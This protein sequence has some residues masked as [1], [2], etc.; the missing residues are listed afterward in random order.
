F[1]TNLAAGAGRGDLVAAAVE[2]LL[3]SSVDA[4]L[5]AS[6]TAFSTR[7]TDGVTYSQGEGA[8][9]FGVSALQ[10]AA[11]SSAT[12]DGQTF[13]LTTD[14][15]TPAMTTGDDTITATSLTLSNDDRITDGSTT[16]NDTLNITATRTLPTAM[17][18]TNVENIVIDWDSYA[19]PD[20]DLTE[21]SGSTVTISSS[22]Q[23]YFGHVDFDGVGTNAVVAGSGMDGD[24]TTDDAEDTT[25][26]AD[27]AN[28]LTMT[29]GDGALTVNA[30]AAE[31]ISIAGGDS[32]VLNA[33]AADDVTAN[34]G[35]FDTAE[36]NL[37]VDAD[38]TFVGAADAVVTV[39][40]A[41]DIT[42]SIQNGFVGETITLG[43]DGA[44]TL[45]FATAADAD[46]VAVTNGGVVN[47]SG[48]ISAALDLS[49]VSASQIRIEST[50]DANALTVASGATVV[51]EIDPGAIAVVAPGT[52]ADSS[53]DTLNVIVE[54]D[55]T[56][57]DFATA[58]TN[59]FETVNMDIDE[60][61]GTGTDVTIA[62]IVMGTTGSTLTVTSEENDLEVT[63]L[64]AET[65]DFSGVASDVTVSQVAAAA[66]DMTISGSSAGDN[67]V[68]FTTD[69]EEAIYIGGAGDD[70]VTFVTD[71]GDATAS[72]GDG[73]NTVDA[74]AITTGVLS[75]IGGTG[76]DNVDV[77][78]LTTGSV[79]LMLGDGDNTMV[80]GANTTLGGA[81]VYIETGAGDDTLTID[82]DTNATDEILAV[83]GDGED[84]LL[85]E[86]SDLTLG[87]VTISG[88]EVIDMAA[89]VTAN[90]SDG[91][92]NASLVSGQSI[93]V[94]GDADA[95][96]DG[97][98]TKLQVVSS[99][100]S[101]ATVALD[102]STL[103]MDRS[104]DD[105]VAGVS[106]SFTN[107]PD[108][109]VIG[110]DQDDIIATGTG[111]VD[112]TPGQGADDI[113][114]G[115]GDNTV[116]IAWADT[117]L[118]PGAPGTQTIDF[119]AAFDDGEDFLD[120]PVAGT[121]ANYTEVDGAGATTFAAALTLAQ[122]ALDG[123]TLFALIYNVD[124]TGGTLAKAT[125]GLDA[126]DAILVYDA[127]GTN[128]G[129]EIIILADI[130]AVGDFDFANII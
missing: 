14:D 88:L 102:F 64:T 61:T 72:L 36:L 83:L 59:D 23:G 120:L 66:F 110:T 118:T 11:G 20:V 114:L 43:G 17:D 101:T 39:N 12:A 89:N 103:T 67:T 49:D 85:L 18:V 119:I 91:I 53:S 22:K 45:D 111:D 47:I 123:T 40:S 21:V 97:E 10:T 65:A 24:V 30:A 41:E 77:T 126:D 31:T 13:E 9:V 92:V 107:N 29:N 99:A 6:A 28:S 25:V 56:G 117:G 70:D 86:D 100:A 51:Y 129:E 84:T 50:D 34:G 130:S 27:L 93:T 37:G 44:V 121:S 42:V 112:V 62:A 82:D 35:N 55:S 96:A 54:A 80:I 122:T 87:T 78:A 46:E 16:D 48:G 7:V 2:Y 3:G 60:A 124:G 69:A 106:L 109:S 95:G 26:T 98:Y 33:A 58:G 128:G 113:T 108:G 116:T 5:T 73:D 90:L 68:V 8:S 75:V 104:I 76:D 81:E 32:L 52:S 105:A 115:T 94:K 71:A 1:T 74:T 63:A 79:S 19:T 127:D 15:D 38:L 57:L 4:S 125:D